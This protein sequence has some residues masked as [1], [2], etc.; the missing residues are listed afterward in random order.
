[1]RLNNIPFRKTRGGLLS[2]S[3]LLTGLAVASNASA[4]QIMVQVDNLAPDQ[5]ATL[6]PLWSG[7]HGG[8]FDLFDFGDPASEALER[9][10]EDGDTGPAMDAFAATT[11]NGVQGTLPA[12]IGPGESLSMG[13]LLNDSEAQRYFSYAAMVVPSNDAFISNDDPKAYSI[14]DDE[15]K[16]TGTDFVV[17]GSDVWDAGTE[18]NSEVPEET[19]LLG[20]TV[21]DTG[22][23]E[24]GVVEPHPGLME[25]GDGG[26]V[27]DPRFTNA[28]FSS[29]GYELARITVSEREPVSVSEPST[30]ALLVGGFL[31]AFLGARRKRK[32]A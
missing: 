24:N 14:F 6:T 12:A 9:L 11:P 17:K 13:F 4:T 5:G 30:L 2:A 21:P 16:F 32:P 27:D 29:E 8:D 18:V 22:T 25:P 15:G 23:D 7:F 3:I 31:A 19:A 20:Q 28:D 26:I 1:M 10:A